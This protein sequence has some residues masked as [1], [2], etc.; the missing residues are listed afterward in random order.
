[1]FKYDDIKNSI[2]WYNDLSDSYII[3]DDLI[4]ELKDT[5]I[6]LKSLYAPSSSTDELKSADFEYLLFILDIIQN[7]L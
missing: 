2:I 6:E 5:I 4:A 7:K 1:M 3:L